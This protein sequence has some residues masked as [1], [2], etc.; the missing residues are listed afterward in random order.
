MDLQYSHRLP[1]PP[2][3]PDSLMQK[4]N[5]NEIVHLINQANDSRLWWAVGKWPLLPEELA[6]KME[7]NGD[8]LTFM[9]YELDM[10]EYMYHHFTK[11][12]SVV[13]I[14]NY[15][16]LHPQLHG[17]YDEDEMEILHDYIGL[18]A[19]FFINVVPYCWEPVEQHLAK[20]DMDTMECWL[21]NI[22]KEYTIK[23]R[24]DWEDVQPDETRLGIII[25]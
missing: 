9:E 13:L 10:K 14:A 18:T 5:N 25:V 2:M 1:P 3:L 24:P 11:S 20:E 16:K 22:Y 4:L 8:H 21:Y 6:D 12:P 19:Q 7:E 23:P 15:W 17:E